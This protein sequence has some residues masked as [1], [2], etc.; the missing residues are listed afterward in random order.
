MGRPACAIVP[1]AYNTGRSALSLGCCGAHLYG[2][3]DER[4]GALGNSWF[5]TRTLRERIA[6]LA[7]ANAVLT[8]FHQVRRKDVE[9]GKSPTIKES[10][11]AMASR[12]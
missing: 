5:Q 1:Q 4:R 11:V 8:T 2:R 10:L 7:Q 12:S 6:A 9:D 3:A